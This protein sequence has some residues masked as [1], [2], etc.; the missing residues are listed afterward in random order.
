MQIDIDAVDVINNKEKKRF[1]VHIGEHVAV[2]DYIPAITRKHDRF[3]PHRGAPKNENEALEGNGLGSKMAREAQ[4]GLRGRIK[5]QGAPQFVCP[6]VAAF[7]N[8][9]GTRNIASR[10][11]GSTNISTIRPG[12]HNATPLGQV[13]T[14]GAISFAWENS[15]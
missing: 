4:I 15:H 8:L 12:I 5:S 1:E 6:Y 3:H 10:C 13:T 14:V 2:M 11:L 9:A 7:I